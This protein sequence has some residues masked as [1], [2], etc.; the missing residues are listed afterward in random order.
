MLAKCT[1]VDEEVHSSHQHP[2]AFLTRPRSFRPVSCIPL[3]R[4]IGHV[5][6]PLLR[7]SFSNQ[8]T[9]CFARN[10]KDAYPPGIFIV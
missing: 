7:V 2:S 3:S 1:Q 4:P 6:N 10:I 5:H 8:H 9:D